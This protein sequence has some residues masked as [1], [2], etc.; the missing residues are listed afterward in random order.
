RIGI[1]A[2]RLR[3]E[4]FAKLPLVEDEAD[5]V[6]GRE[7]SL[8]SVD[9]FLSK[10]TLFQPLVV[11]AGCVCQRAM[12]D[13]ISDDLLDR[14]VG[15]AERPK[16]LR[17]CAVDDLEVA[18]ARELLEL[19]ESEVRLDAG[20]VAIHDKADRACR[21]DDGGLRIAIAIALTH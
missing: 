7:R 1:E 10:P 21:G 12:T 19:H 5:V 8:D 2:E 11:H 6:G 20:R 16:R 9:F 3:A 13:S 18:A 4:L 14:L 17:H 15:I